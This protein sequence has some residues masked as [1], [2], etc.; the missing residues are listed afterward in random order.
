[1]N[2][3]QINGPRVWRGATLEDV[4]SRVVLSEEPSVA[5]EKLCEVVARLV[6]RAA[7]S[8]QDAL[9]LIAPYCEW[10]VEE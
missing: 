3:E 2:L 10:R 8:E 9:D 1:M 4:L 5:M 6:E 7:T